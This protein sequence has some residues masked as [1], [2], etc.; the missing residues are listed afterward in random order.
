MTSSPRIAPTVD[1]ERHRGFDGG[2]APPDDVIIDDDLVD[3]AVDLARDLLVASLADESSGE[4]RRRHRLGRLL[5]DENGRELILAL[6]DEVL[7]M[8]DDAAA[9]QRF[10]EC[11]GSLPTKAIGRVDRLFLRLGGVIGRRLPAVVM[12]LV[13]RRIRR[14]TRGIV[15]PADDPAFARHLAQRARDGFD[16]NVNPLGEAILSDDEA[17]IRLATVLEMIDRDD[18]DYVSVKISAIVANLDVLAFDESIERVCA[19][20]RDLYRA[21]AAARTTTFVNLD[22]EEYRDLELTVTAFMRV[23]DEAE[24]APTRAGIVL[25]AYLPDSHDVADR[26]VR[27][28]R[29][30]RE[31]HPRSG[32]I[33]VRLVKGANLA[34]ELVEAELHGWV[35]APYPSK[36]DVDAS[37]KA[38][39]DTLLRAEVA[40]I[41]EVGVASHN[42]F[43]VAWAITL[44]GALGASD[45]VEFEMLEG[46]AP[47]QARA[48]H[49]RTGSV[50]MYSPVVAASDFAASIAYL[51]RRLDENTQPD[52]FLRSLF[53]LQPDTAEFDEQTARFRQAVEQ[54]HT[55]GRDRLRR[56]RIPPRDRFDNEPETDFTDPA[57]RGAL[58][59]A[60]ENIQ[61][62]E[63]AVIDDPAD[64]DLVM[65]AAVTASRRGDDLATRRSWLLGAAQVMRD[66]RFDTLAVMAH[67]TAKTAGEGDAEVSEAIDFCEYY[68][69]I[70]GAHLETLADRG[71][72]V[73]GRGVV[74]VVSPWNF[75]YAIPCGG[76]AAALMAGNAV[77]LKPAPEARLVARHLAEQFWAAGVPRD[78]LHLVLCD[79]GPVGQALIAHRCI[80]T[81]VLTGSIE[82]ASMFLEWCPQRR[83]LG[84]TSGKNALVITA[85]ADLDDAIA[86]LIRSAFGHAGQ[87]CSAASLAIVEASV[88]DSATFLPRL[89]AATRSLRVGPAADP[90][91]MM[92]PLIGP[93]SERLLRAVTRLDDGEQWLVEPRRLDDATWTPGVRT[94]VRP[95]S[96]FHR[97][98]CFGPV[99]GVMRAA[100]LDEAIALQNDTDFGLTGGIHS[101]D[102]AEI[103]RWLD[104]VEVG[105]AYVNRQTTGAVVQRQP[106][107]GWKQSNVGGGAK[108]GGPGYVVQFAEIT[109]PDDA[110]ADRL[111]R[112]AQSYA[113]AW[114][115][116]FVGR[117]D[118][119]GLRA[120]S[121]VLRHVP[122]AAVAVRHDGTDP[123]GLA[124]LRLAARTCG[125]AVIESQVGEESEAAFVHRA[126]RADRVRL[127]TGLSDDAHRAFHERNI[128]IDDTPPVSAGDVELRRWLREQAISRTMHRHGRL[129][130]RDVSVS[131][132]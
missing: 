13:R 51:S 63:Y 108:A 6:T 7:R 27:W 62:S 88:Y 129:V 29:A 24:F 75:P 85:A 97:T 113:D 131:R 77:V 25:Q 71:H 9:A 67:E 23:L 45:R 35:A 81:V 59:T 111:E 122:L 68:G 19:R 11:V 37:Y 96:W 101:L 61:L 124:M 41:V 73:H 69:R 103:E 31:R 89:A 10:A 118:P 84:E 130:P 78:V 18:V 49:D 86:D 28:A 125:V 32:R 72:H 4:R 74:A 91:T 14:E 119:A 43:D 56:R 87:K 48:V 102:P 95:G 117:H 34:M 42:L 98:E 128:P 70:G 17:D 99:L 26:L 116:W 55:I 121:N 127:L 20:L 94:G 52:N 76:V 22:M 79:D 15:L 106:F 57:A 44:V 40:D 65:D 64:V 2:M 60:I 107:G 109:D 120:E 38:L 39:L 112:A 114:T 5:A 1:D 47:A 93:P 16:L 132:S 82:T 90:D 80:D 54:R 92:G 36:A 104:R 12:P 58:R 21:G 50:L 123:T 126:G 83:V 115:R 100:D 53:T 105:N 8:S 66:Q 46:M 3:T 30:R 33:K 110:D